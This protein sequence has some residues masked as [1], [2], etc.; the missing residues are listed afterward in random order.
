[1]K[2]RP[3]E[4]QVLDAALAGEIV[5]HSLQDAW[6]VREMLREAAGRAA[7]FDHTERADLFS[8]MAKRVDVP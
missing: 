3:T 4:K 8:E 1:M 5:P 6:W 2:N 7:E